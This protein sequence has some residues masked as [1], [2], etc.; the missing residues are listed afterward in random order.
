MGSTQVFLQR[1]KRVLQKSAELSMRLLVIAVTVLLPTLGTIPVGAQDT[2]CLGAPQPNLRVGIM[3]Q[4]TFTDGSTTR[5]RDAPSTRGNILIE[6]REGQFFQVVGGPQCADGYRWWQLSLSGKQITGWAAEG[7]SDTYFIEPLTTIAGTQERIRNQTVAYR[8]AQPKLIALLSSDGTRI[9][10]VSTGNLNQPSTLYTS[11]QSYLS[12]PQWSSDGRYVAFQSIPDTLDY[13]VELVVIDAYTQATVRDVAIRAGG[14]YAVLSPDLEEAAYVE[15]LSFNNSGGLDRAHGINIMN[16]D[17]GLTRYIPPATETTLSP[18]TT[19]NQ[20]RAM[21]PTAWSPNGNTIAFV[22]VTYFE[23]S[24]TFGFVSVDGSL[25]SEEN[26]SQYLDQLDFDW[27]AN[28]S[29]IY[30]SWAGRLYSS[31]LNINDHT[32]LLGDSSFRISSPQVSP[33]GSLIV[34]KRELNSYAISGSPAVPDRDLWTIYADAPSVPWRIGDVGSSLLGWTDNQQYLIREPSGEVF[35]VN[36][37]EVASSSLGR[38][39]ASC[40]AVQPVDD[41]VWG[42]E[43]ESGPT[44]PS[45]DLDHHYVVFLDGINSFSEAASPLNG[46]FRPIEDALRDLGIAK[47]VYFSYGAA[48]RLQ[49]G[50]LACDGWFEGCATTTLGDLAAL[51]LAPIYTSDD[52]KLDVDLQAQMLNWL[53]GEVVER[54]PSAQID[55]VGYSLGGIVAS[56]WASRWA[57]MGDGSPQGKTEIGQHIHCIVLIESPVGGI[58]GAQAILENRLEGIA[59]AH[60]L[61][62]LFGTNVLRAMQ[63]SEGEG[64][65]VTSLEDAAR[66]FN[67]VSIQS[68]TDF[69]VNGSPLNIVP[70]GPTPMGLGTQYWQADHIR[71]YDQ[72]LG[73]Q[74]GNSV[75]PLG[76][77]GFLG[78][79]HGAPLHYPLTI[80]WVTE[81]VTA[82]SD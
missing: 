49:M 5:L 66:A 28:P 14:R 12:C 18:E 70:F 36:G 65:I 17:S 71:H 63:M 69:L 22:G 13:T 74:E 50:D 73:G 31:S 11:S 38:L 58:F 59:W 82:P 79:N 51:D 4:V 29:S 46:D 2:A 23:G 76:L 53:L 57:L 68:S 78:S 60:H 20:N 34:V 54:D 35:L 75:S 64:S 43:A 52:T 1:F 33:D 61:R 21:I 27:D 39:D 10:V 15:P 44:G 80:Q 16:L 55:L 9:Q 47:F 41:G 8:P 19:T 40:A 67:V 81:A 37:I 24:Q 26:V 6:M 30:Y 3:G 25:V 45:N 62:N 7:D 32:W 72:N 56:R 77:K 42:V 48:S